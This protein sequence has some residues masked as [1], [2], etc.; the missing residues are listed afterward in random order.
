MKIMKKKE[1]EMQRENKPNGKAASAVNALVIVQRDC[2]EVLKGLPDDCCDIFT[3]PPYNARKDYGAGIDDDLP[4]E[5]YVEWIAEVF[6]EA[7]RVSNVLTVYTPHNWQMEYWQILGPEFKQI[8][9]WHPAKNGFYKNF[10]N[11]TAILLTNAV[12]KK[13]EQVENIWEVQLPGIGYYS[14]EPK[15]DHVGYTTLDVTRKAIERLCNSDLIY[16]PFIGSGTTPIAAE[17]AGK[18]WAGT[19]LNPQTIQRAEKRIEEFRRQPTF[20]L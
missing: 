10:V 13:K 5:E 6:K 14:K 7:K 15:N 20:A 8:V 4:E 17:M 9:L 16:D 3:D 11:K 18:E 2:L 1:T 12:P 19:E